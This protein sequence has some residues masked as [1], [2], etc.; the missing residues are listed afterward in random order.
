VAT[1]DLLTEGFHPTTF[2]SN[3][4]TF[5]NGVWFPPPTVNLTFGIDNASSTV[6]AL[7]FGAFFSSPNVMLVG[8][9]VTGP[10]CGFVRVHSWQAHVPAQTFTSGSV[11]VFCIDDFIGAN[12]ALEALLAGQVVASDSFTITQSNP[13]TARHETLSVSGV[14]FDRLRFIVTGGPPGGDENGILAFFDNVTLSGCYP[15]CNLDT[16]LTVLDFGCFQTKFV[17]GDTYADCNADGQLTV[18]DFGC[19]QTK[20]VAGCP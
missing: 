4:V 10:T 13:G 20:F 14:V 7:G 18:T 6:P 3:G 8:G 9:F 1:F 5:S 2:V 11:E 17:A 16:V 12:V 19:F 15:D